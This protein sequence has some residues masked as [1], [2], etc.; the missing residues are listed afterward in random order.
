M[1]ATALLVVGGLTQLTY[2]WMAYGIMAMPQG[3]GPETAVLVLRNLALVC[4]AG[5]ALWL[6][7]R[8]SRATTM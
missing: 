6:T 4:L 1:L 8:A 7:L 2:P 3:S 5:Y